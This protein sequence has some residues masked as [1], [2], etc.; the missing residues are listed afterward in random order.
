MKRFF[1][2]VEDL[3]VRVT[4]WGAEDAPV[5]FCMHGLGST[6]LSFIELAEAVKDEFRV[7]AI[8][9][10][11][12]GM[13]A[14]FPTAEQYG[15]PYLADWLDKVIKTLQ[16]N[17]F[18]FLSHSWGSFISLF[19]F[20]AFP[21]KVMGAILIDGGYQSK[22][23]K[24]QPVEEE[25]A[26]YEEDFEGYTETWESFLTEAVYGGGTRRSP[27]LDLAAQDLVLKKDGRFYWHARGAVAGHI[28]RGMHKHEVHD[29]YRKQ[30]F[31]VVLLRA[32]MPESQMEY[33]NKASSLF[34]QKTAA[35][36]KLVAGT[37]HM[38][39]WEKP[40][41]VIDEIK[42]RWLARTTG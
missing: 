32:E 38:L 14:A 17:R 7:V 13:S 37:S 19:Y 3:A 18:Y 1:I 34:E 22:K 28:V 39:H 33:R 2:T 36:V 9:A 25:V 29:V 4:E 23:L 30:P 20:A 6:S 8:D 12:H 41:V 21:Q 10:P 40:E 31:D 11:G 35:T 5:I 16:I 24:G 27:L 15:L 42:G 26:F